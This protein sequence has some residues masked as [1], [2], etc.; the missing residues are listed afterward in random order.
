MIWE[1]GSLLSF[2]GEAGIPEGV[3]VAIASLPPHAGDKCGNTIIRGK[4]H[5]RL[6]WI[7]TTK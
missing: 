6:G 2:E 7:R 3:R 5:P 4:A 1:R